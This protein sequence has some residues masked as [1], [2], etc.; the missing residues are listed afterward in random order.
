MPTP[1]SLTDCPSLIN[2][3]LTGDQLGASFTLKGV[4]CDVVQVEGH[5]CI[6]AVT[7]DFGLSVIYPGWYAGE[8]GAPA[9]VVIV[10][11][12]QNCLQW[13]PIDP[14]D[15]R[16]LINRLPLDQIDKTMFTLAV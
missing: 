9:R 13:L 5:A 6:E 10:G 11:D 14:V 15:K 1:I 12:I 16:A 3:M 4:R 7:P 8:H 2:L